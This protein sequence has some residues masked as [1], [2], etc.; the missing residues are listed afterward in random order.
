MHRKNGCELLKTLVVKIVVKKMQEA[1]ILGFLLIFRKGVNFAKG[2][3]I[4]YHKDNG[5]GFVKSRFLVHYAVSIS[6]T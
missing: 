1:Y 2:L 6:K 4:L 5:G 3:S